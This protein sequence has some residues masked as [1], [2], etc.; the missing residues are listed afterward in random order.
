[1]A[2]RGGLACAEGGRAGL[3][4]NAQGP[5]K[6]L[7]DCREPREVGK[8]L[9]CQRPLDQVATSWSQPRREHA[10]SAQSAADP[11]DGLAER[12]VE[13]REDPRLWNRSTL[14]G[15]VSPE[16]RHGERRSTQASP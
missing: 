13:D 10:A 4:D 8:L 1:M 9:T 11:T 14:T 15:I 16:E 7:A 6:A 2:R 3:V 5:E 12:P